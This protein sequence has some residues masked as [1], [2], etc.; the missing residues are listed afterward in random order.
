MTDLTALPEA[1][2]LWIGASFYKTPRH[3]QMESASMGVC[4]RITSIPRKFEMGK[5]W[6][7]LAHPSTI[8]GENEDGDQVMLPGVFNAFL[9]TSIEQIVTETQ[10]KDAEEMEKLDARGITPV[11]VP[12]DDPDHQ[13]SVYDK[14]TDIAEGKNDA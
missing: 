1:G 5:T 6:V 12:D 4:P 8:P 14:V 13:G 9:P 2:L 11:I 3:F 7:F 10:S